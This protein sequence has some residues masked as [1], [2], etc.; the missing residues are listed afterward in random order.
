MVCPTIGLI[1]Y[2]ITI[3]GGFFVRYDVSKWGTAYLG[4]DI[5]IYGILYLLCILIVALYCN[6]KP[7]NM[8]GLIHKYD[9]QGD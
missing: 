2:Y 7:F 5:V 8:W 3:F 1:L 6:M 4:G 9:E